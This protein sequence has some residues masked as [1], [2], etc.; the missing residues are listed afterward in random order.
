LSFLSGKFPG[1]LCSL[2]F[3]PQPSTLAGKFPMALGSAEKTGND[4]KPQDTKKNESNLLG[5]KSVRN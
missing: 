2:K 1:S 5:K 3:N 4:E